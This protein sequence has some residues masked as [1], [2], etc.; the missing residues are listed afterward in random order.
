MATR[1]LCV[2]VC[3]CV[4]ANGAVHLGVK[5]GAGESLQFYKVIRL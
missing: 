4:K 2:G 1:E 5:M 3:D